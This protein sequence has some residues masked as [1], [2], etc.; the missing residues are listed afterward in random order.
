MLSSQLE[1]LIGSA[2][3]LARSK[4]H[5]NVTTE[6]L[7]YALLASPEVQQ[8]LAFCGCDVA[9]VRRDTLANIEKH[10]L[11]I[12]EKQYDEAVPTLGFQ[13]VIHRAVHHSQAQDEEQPTYAHHALLSLYGETDS[14]AVHTLVAHGVSEV[15]LQEFFRKKT[16]SEARATRQ[17]SSTSDKKSPLAVFAEHLN[18]KAADGGIDPLIGREMELTR[19]TQI[20]ARRNKNNPLL[21]GDAGVGKTAIVQG[22]AH[23]IEQGLVPDVLSNAQIFALDVGGLLAGS[24]YRGDFEVRIKKVLEALQ[25][26]RYAILF[27]DEIHTIIGAGATTGSS[28]DIAN[29]LK[30]M[31]GARNLRCIGSTTFAEYRSTFSKDHA[32]A[33]RF[34]KIVVE[35]PST[36]QAC[37]ILQGLR[38]RFEQFHTVSISDAAIHSAVALSQKY[39]HDTLLPD[40]AIDVLDEAC[41]VQSLLPEK[42]RVATLTP[43]EISAAVA[44]MANLPNEQLS[45]SQAEHIAHLTSN[46]QTMIYGQSRAIEV[47]CNRIKLA[48]AGLAQPNRPTGCFLFTGPTGVGKTELCRQLANVLHVPLLRFDMSEYVEKHSVARLVGAPPGYVGYEEGGL[49]T[50][51]VHKNPHSIVLL[52]EIEKAHPDLYNLLL[53]VMDHGCLTDS[54]GRTTHFQHCIVVMTSNTGSEQLAKHSIGFHNTTGGDI[55]EEIQRVFSPEFRNRLDAIVPFV[56]LDQRTIASVLEKFLVQ[57]SVSLTKKSVE[58][59]VSAA[60]KRWCIKHGYNQTMGARPMGRLVDSH[61]A[62]PIADAV[63]F[64]ELKQGG[65]AKVDVVR[66][67]IVLRYQPTP[68]SCRNTVIKTCENA[69]RV[70]ASMTA[71]CIVHLYR[72]RGT[73]RQST[74]LQRAISRPLVG[75]KGDCLGGSAGGA[76]YGVRRLLTAANTLRQQYDYVFTSGGIGSTHDDITAAAIAEAF[77]RPLV[78]HPEAMAVLER[79]FHSKGGITPARRKM[80]TIPEQALLIHHGEMGVPG[81]AVDNVYVMAGV[82]EIFQAM[83]KGLANHLPSLVPIVAYKVHVEAGESQFAEGL[84][85]VQQRFADVE[86]GSYPQHV[87]GRYNRQFT[88][89]TVTATDTKRISACVAA[90]DG[91]LDTLS[92]IYRHE[93][94]GSTDDA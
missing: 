50:D 42:E 22:L 47:V 27:I 37:A 40:K 71:A 2:F 4:L 29:I 36:E 35:Q 61:I 26:F 84:A 32:L 73:V 30:P 52:D 14:Y 54:N 65:I 16:I 23:R 81:F 10:N 28:L 1:R 45:A 3:E 13:R 67:A 76:R 66:D 90:M 80:A 72:Q 11:A 38:P 56:P 57:L 41:A 58:L 60:A 88:E 44:T 62:L 85:E 39:L 5:A 83:V 82:P 92:I 46:L 7:L 89:L 49:L 69:C 25:R 31:L 12:D 94:Y 55:S 8:C 53:Q 93:G 48:R 17:A 79:V 77:Q 6:H 24:K 68:L 9:A 33:R 75:N 64:G 91:L 19:M 18:Q 87:A 21:V 74:R 51:G 43:T 78:E 34:Q 70:G 63:L 59:K 15:S 86:I 20:L